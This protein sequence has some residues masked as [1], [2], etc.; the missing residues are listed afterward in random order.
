MIADDILGR[1][2]QIHELLGQLRRPDHVRLVDVDILVA[3]GKP[4][5]VL[6]ELLA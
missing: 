4:K 5:P 6:A 3:G 2:G 1:C